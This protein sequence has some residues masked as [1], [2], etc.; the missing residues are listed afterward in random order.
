MMMKY[1]DDFVCAFPYRD[2]AEAFITSLTE[3]LGKF[4]LELA[5]EKS[6]LVAFSRNRLEMN[7][8]FAFLVFR[9]HWTL[10]RKGIRKGQ[11]MTDAKK[12]ASLSASLQRVDSCQAAPTDHSTHGAAT[13]Q[14][15]QI[16]ELPRGYGEFAQPREIRVEGL[17]LL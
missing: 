10:S 3:G 1:I 16:L 13:A 12:R 15:R 8:S 17:G 7:G 2:E 6:V 14:T 9:Y 4:N 11:R 5:G